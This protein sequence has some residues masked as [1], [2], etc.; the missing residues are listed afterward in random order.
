MQKV[1]E[2]CKCSPMVLYPSKYP[3]CEGHGKLCMSEL[4]KD[5][6]SHKQIVDKG[7]TKECLVA[8]HDQTH[9]FVTTAASYPNINSFYLGEDYCLVLE[10]L[11]R[12]C[13]TEHRIT[14]G[15]KYPALCPL[16]DST[17]ATPCEAT[18]NQSANI[19]LD[20]LHKLVA[21]YARENLSV[22]D[23]Y[24]KDP[25]V[26]LYLR[27]EKITVIS[28]IGNTGG[29]LGLFLGFSFIS[30]IEIISIFL[31]FPIK[32]PNGEIAN[33]RSDKRGRTVAT[34]VSSITKVDSS[35]TLPFEGEME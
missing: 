8:C 21:K 24:I 26:K 25:Y 31:A 9:Q 6:G 35:N 29:L 7:E 22:L 1:E 27:R 17:S 20:K 23:V 12:S 34:H 3:P 30:T 2:I 28:F 13:K 4:M 16:I 15:M 10:K 14:L 18:K 5:I 33:E 11:K 32:I 19:D